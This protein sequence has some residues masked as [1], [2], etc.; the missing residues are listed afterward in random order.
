MSTDIVDELLAIQDQVSDWGIGT[1]PDNEKP[2]RPSVFTPESLREH[3]EPMEKMIQELIRDKAEANYK[4]TGFNTDPLSIITITVD[5]ADEPKL[6][7]RQYRIP[8]ALIPLVQKVIDR[9]AAE[10]RI[11]PCPVR[12]VINNP[13][14]VAPK[15]DE[16]GNLTGIRVC[17]DPRLVN[18]YMKEDDKFEIPRIA[19]LLT[20]FAGKT[21]FGEFDLSEAYLQFMLHPDSRKYTTFTWKTQMQFVGTPYGLKP[22]PNSFQRY[23]THKFTHLGNVFPYIDNLAHAASSWR[24]HIDTI[25]AVIDECDKVNLRIKP[26]SIRVAQAMLKIL[27]H[28]LAPWGIGVDPQKAATVMNWPLPEDCAN[29]RAFFGFAGFLADHIRHF[30]DLRAPFD[31]LKAQDGKI[32]WNPLLISQ[33]KAVQQAIAQAPWLKHPDP[34]KRFA[35][36]TDAS[37]L[38]YGGV[39]FQP[40]DDTNTITPHNIVAIFSKKF[41]ETQRR[42]PVY[43]KEGCAVIFSLLRFHSYIAMT[44]FTLITDHLPL[45]FLQEQHSLSA[46]AMQWIDILSRY[47]FTIVHRPGIMHVVP[48]ALSRL[49]S[50]TYKDGAAWG[51]QPNIKYQ[52]VVNQELSPSDKLCADSIEKERQACEKRFERLN[53][54]R[55]RQRKAMQK[56]SNQ[57]SISQISTSSS[58]HMGGSRDKAGQ[59]VRITVSSDY[60]LW[61]ACGR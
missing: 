53:A 7:R 50:L 51:T 59:F 21:I 13:L 8:F 2:D 41:T 28:I 49:F 56:K 12:T 3:Y 24:E 58:T 20:A 30:A 11:E 23:M 19:D 45:K 39:L 18:K 42:Y 16:N 27:G 15:K 52:Q 43:K 29:L 46:S 25:L 10:H 48:D 33:F 5:P 4:R 37:D 34:H 55:T 47:N 44:H 36:A 26:G 32:I 14:L 6:F 61:H 40:D 38:A 22:I 17:I 35:I 57:P 54:L 31:K 60:I 9:W 1:I